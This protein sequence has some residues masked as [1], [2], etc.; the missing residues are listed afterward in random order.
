MSGRAPKQGGFVRVRV[1]AAGQ[2]ML[3]SNLDDP[4]A[5]AKILSDACGASISRAHEG[6]QS[7]ILRASG[8]MLPREN[9]D[10]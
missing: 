7:P 2:S 6:E 8:P 9:G 10:G 4:L 5:I 1:N 3:G